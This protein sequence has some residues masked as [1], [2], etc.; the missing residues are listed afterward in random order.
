MS[1]A[2]ARQWGRACALVW[3]AANGFF[4]HLFC[5]PSERRFGVGARC[6]GRGEARERDVKSSFSWAS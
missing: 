1:G 3:A 5:R 4:S 2:F 6:D